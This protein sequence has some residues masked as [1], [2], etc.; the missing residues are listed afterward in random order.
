MQAGAYAVPAARL[1]TEPVPQP[2]DERTEGAAPQSTKETDDHATEGGPPHSVIETVL[3]CLEDPRFD[4]RTPETISR[5][6]GLTVPEVEAAL[7][8]LGDVVRHPIGDREKEQRYYRLSSRG[9]TLGERVRRV[10][11]MV[12]RG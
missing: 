8:A 4:W 12:T 7:S 2:P 9:L 5:A 6:S 10:R 3:K 11:E 1:I